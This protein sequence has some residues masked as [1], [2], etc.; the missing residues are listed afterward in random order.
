MSILTGDKVIVESLSQFRQ[1]ANVSWG[2]IAHALPETKQ[3]E[4]LSQAEE[5]ID[6][7][8]DDP[9]GELADVPPEYIEDTV[10]ERGL[11]QTIIDVL[12]DRVED[13]VH[14]YDGTVHTIVKLDG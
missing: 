7:W 11:N 3:E 1:F 9:A 4:L 13:Y 5:Y 8:N 2:E 10:H 6:G 14:L 12:E